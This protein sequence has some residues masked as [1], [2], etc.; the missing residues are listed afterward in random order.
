MGRG[1]KT[2]AGESLGQSPCWGFLGKGE[3][4]HDEQLGL[5]SL[6]LSYRDSPYLPGSRPWEDEGRGTP[7]PGL[8]VRVE[9][10]GSGI[11]TL[12]SR[13]QLGARPFVI[14]KNWPAQEGQSSQ[15]ERFF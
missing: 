13:G 8:F 3:A 10:S 6:A 2:G 7:P 9:R 5:A 15:V 14:S 1:Q 4:G 11:V 12:H